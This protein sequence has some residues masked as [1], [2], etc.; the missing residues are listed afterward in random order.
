M[1]QFGFPG[2]PYNCLDTWYESWT[3]ANIKNVCVDEVANG[4]S[5]VFVNIKRLCVACAS[6]E[7]HAYK[8]SQICSCLLVSLSVVVCVNPIDFH[9][10]HDISQLQMLLKTHSLHTHYILKKNKYKFCFPHCN[11]QAMTDPIPQWLDLL[12]FSVEWKLV[13]CLFILLVDKSFR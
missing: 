11:Y 7:A 12:A 6:R 1:P 8:P 13:C 3:R 2:L 9:K 5:F 10:I 4:C